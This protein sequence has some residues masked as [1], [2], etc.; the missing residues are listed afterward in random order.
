[1]L[2]GGAQ[3]EWQSALC[4]AAR[5]G[6]ARSLKA[7]LDGDADGN[8]ADSFGN[9]ALMEAV[10]SKQKACARML[11]PHSNLG[12]TSRQGK[13]A[14]HISVNTG[15]WDCFSMLVKRTGDLDERMVQGIDPESGE[16]LV[17]FGRTALYLAC[18]KGQ[19][20][21][22]AVLLHRGASRTARDSMGC[23]PAYAAGPAGRPQDDPRRG[24]CCSD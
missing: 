3:C 8:A 9:T 12:A 14:F 16:T 19:H 1:M 23:S 4:L 21:M 6:K 22:A 20:D 7:M 15:N 11:L 13:T 10:M 2:C 24:G 18:E 17:G 5:F